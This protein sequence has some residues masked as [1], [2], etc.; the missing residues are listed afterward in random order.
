M[1]V[2][3]HEPMALFRSAI[4]SKVTRRYYEKRLY[5]FLKRLGM[6]EKTFLSNS[7]QD[8]KW[9]E[10]HVLQYVLELRE[11]VENEEISPA[12]LPNY[13]KPIKLFL[14]MNDVADINWKK[15]HRM[16]PRY[17]NYADDRAPT[18]E[19]IRMLCNE[20]DERIKV[21]VPVMVSSGI[22]IGA[23][24][25]LRWKHVKPVIKE[26]KVVAARLTVYAG[27]PDEYHTFITPEACK[28]ISDYMEF[29]KIHGETITGDSPLLRDRFVSTSG[30]GSAKFVKPLKSAGLK[31]LME[32]ALW[33]LG[34]RQE[35]KVR[36]EFQ[37]N[38]GFR[39]FF[40]TRAEQVM[41]PINVEVLLGHSTGLSDS[42]YRPLEDDIL[43]DYLKAVP[44]LTISQEL[45]PR[46]NEKIEE[47]EKRVQEYETRI[48]QLEGLTGDEI[49][50]RLY[51]VAK[52]LAGDEIKRI[53]DETRKGMEERVRKLFGAGAYVVIDGKIG[54]LQSG[55]V[56][57]ILKEIKRNKCKH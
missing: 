44:Y 39:K 35:K 50:K 1:E 33:K 16:Y 10:A 28:A 34:I 42:Y 4:K 25:K 23:W 43:E 37:V 19:E 30:Y 57:S 48:K 9:C 20:G 47:L 27:E 26:E 54:E 5:I 18:I 46:N 15:I 29:R 24:D 12:T 6:D 41:K 56:S 17:R 49:D 32:R 40:K 55:G 51:D 11:R 13:I 14:D 2:L 38:H 52:R 22:R 3:V 36:H 53:E 45:K 21:A 31:H 8:A 7:K